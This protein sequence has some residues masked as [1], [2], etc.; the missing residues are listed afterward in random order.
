MAIKQDVLIFWK[1]V[2]FIAEM[3]G[4]HALKQ[5]VQKEVCNFQE[6]HTPGVLVGMSF[7]VK[8]N[9]RINSQCRRKNVILIV[10]GKSDCGPCPCDLSS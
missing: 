3:Q 8:T 9:Y 1:P 4:C 10:N 5:Y 7:V 6:F 2:N